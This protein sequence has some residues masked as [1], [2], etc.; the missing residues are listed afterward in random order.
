[1]KKKVGRIAFQEISVHI[2]FIESYE[3]TLAEEGVA[4][5]SLQKSIDMFIVS[6]VLCSK[7]ES[8][9]GA[10]LNAVDLGSFSSQ[11]GMFQGY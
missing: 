3:I 6:R 10:I 9:H 4:F 2:I 11:K 7:D 8:F 5:K 1:M